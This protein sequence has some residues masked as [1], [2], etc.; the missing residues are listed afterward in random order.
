MI[1]HAKDFATYLCLNCYELTYQDIDK[2]GRVWTNLEDDTSHL[3]FSENPNRYTIDEIYNEYIE[4][5]K[6][7]L[8]N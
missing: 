4:L 5:E 2:D 3:S 1:E 6:E 7:I 8:N